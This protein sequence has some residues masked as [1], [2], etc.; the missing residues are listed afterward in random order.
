MQMIKLDSDWQLHFE[1]VQQC[2]LNE[3][4]IVIASAHMLPMV[5]HQLYNGEGTVKRFEFVRKISRKP[6]TQL[7]VHRNIEQIVEK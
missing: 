4:F 2:N 7:W 1:F 6:A 5:W 3:Y